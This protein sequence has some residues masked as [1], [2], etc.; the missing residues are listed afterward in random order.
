MGVIIMSV[1]KQCLAEA[2]LARHIMNHSILT[3]CSCPEVVYGSS[4]IIPKVIKAKS[5]HY[6]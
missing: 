5:A 1:N 3:S 2:I 4:A 6:A